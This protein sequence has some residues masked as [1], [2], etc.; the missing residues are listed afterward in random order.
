MPPKKSHAAASKNKSPENAEQ[1]KP[2]DSSPFQFVISTN[3]LEARSKANKK[4]VR[5]VAALK[6]WPERR[7]KTFEGQDAS[8]SRGGFVLDRNVSSGPSKPA[9]AGTN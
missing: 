8:S 4:R 7:K 9:A 6:S 5:S 1:S 2:T 3:P